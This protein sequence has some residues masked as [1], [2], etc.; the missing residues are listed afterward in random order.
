M[1]IVAPS[2]IHVMPPDC[3]PWN[4]EDFPSWAATV[5]KGLDLCAARLGGEWQGTHSHLIDTR[6]VHR[7]MF[8][9]LTELAHP[10]FAGHYRGQDHKCLRAYAVGVSNDPKVGYAPW[11][12]DSAMKE[13]ADEVMRTIGK[14]DIF[15]QQKGMDVP[16][17][18]LTIVRV[19]CRLFELFLRIHPYANG[20]GHAARFLFLSLLARYEIK[21]KTWPVEPRPQPPYGDH[22]ALY[23]RAILGDKK[24]STKPFETWM[25]DQVV[26]SVATSSPPPP[27]APAPQAP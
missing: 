11:L 17:K 14:A 3:R 21:P 19:G 22:L 8:C 16:R 25:L 4:Y 26:G 12:V 18:I 5:T 6:E 13:F 9:Q 15:W 7:E 20:N 1:R 23:R 24:A 10:Y 2:G 27:S